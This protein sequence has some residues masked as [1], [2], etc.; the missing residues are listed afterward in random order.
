MPWTVFRP[1][2]V[3]GP[4]D[5]EL[6]P[7]LR[8]MEHG[9]VPVL[10]PDEARFSLAYVDDVARAVQCWLAHSGEAGKVYELHDGCSGGYSWGEFIAIGERLLQRRVRRLPVPASALGL[11][12]A[13]NVALARL[14]GRAPM[15]TPG[16]VRELRY[17]DWVCDNRA[18]GNALG[19]R[20]EV[21]LD[22]GL[23]RA[24]DWD[25]SL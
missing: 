4:G 25:G 23:R 10:A 11:I 8:S 6:L 15:L 19:W 21:D 5:R 18:I 9:L 13:G 22:N 1:P 3:Y 16:K 7:L 20:P 17:P 2:A 24:L 12:A 14:L